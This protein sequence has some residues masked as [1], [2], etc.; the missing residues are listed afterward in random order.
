MSTA[1][2][3]IEPV[4]PSRFNRFNTMHIILYGNKPFLYNR[5]KYFK[6]RA[7]KSYFKFFKNNIFLKLIVVLLA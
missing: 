5:L 2:V 4:I 7:I 6:T 1:A 3:I